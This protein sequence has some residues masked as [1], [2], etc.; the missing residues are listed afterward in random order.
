MI[1]TALRI[2]AGRTA[3]RLASLGSRLLLVHAVAALAFATHAQAPP[4]AP[5]R[6][7]KE[8]VVSANRYA[9]EAGLEILREGGNAVDAAIAVQL[10]LSLV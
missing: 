10:V 1:A 7:S 9:S 8:M 6:A 2:P 5:V 3:R 4:S